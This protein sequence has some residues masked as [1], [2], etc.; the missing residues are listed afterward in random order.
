MIE[1]AN[2][3]PLPLSVLARTLKVGR[4]GRP[5]H[6]N[7]LMRWATRGLRGVRLETI[8]CGART[9]SS[10]EALQRFFSAL[11]RASEANL[12]GPAPTIDTGREAEAATRELD[13]LL[14]N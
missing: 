2:E 14:G 3:V 9:C 7:T 10:A 5:T 1:I 8:K 12:S 11:T 4:L 13:Q 6:P